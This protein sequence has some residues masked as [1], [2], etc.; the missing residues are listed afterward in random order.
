MGIPHTNNSVIPE[1]WFNSSSASNFSILYPPIS[2]SL[3]LALN[4]TS[5]TESLSCSFA[6]GCTLELEAEGL[7]G[8]LKNDSIANKITVCEEKCEF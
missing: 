1:I 7:S 5:S 4:V 8:M 6:G 3:N 2:S